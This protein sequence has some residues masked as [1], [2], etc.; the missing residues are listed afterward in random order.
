MTVTCDD[1][2]MTVALEKAI[3]PY[4]NAS[5]LHLRSSSCGATES[6][7]HLY[8][9]TELDGCRTSVAETSSS[10]IFTNEIQADI[11]QISSAVTRDHDFDLEFNC[12]YPKEKFLSLSFTPD[13][14][15]IPPLQGI[16]DSQL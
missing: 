15:D 10:L 6:A 2:N 16:M 12:S 3:Y 8:L 11:V 9:A 14:I 5:L 7:T 4:L 13:G 1:S